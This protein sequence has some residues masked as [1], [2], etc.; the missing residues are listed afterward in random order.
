[1]GFLATGFLRDF[2]VRL[3]TVT[4]HEAALLFPFAF[5]QKDG[6]VDLTKEELAHL[7]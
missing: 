7:R 1:M 4:L 6:R 5:V 3:Y 2:H